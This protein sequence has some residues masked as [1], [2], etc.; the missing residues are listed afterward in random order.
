MVLAVVSMGREGGKKRKEGDGG[1]EGGKGRRGEREGREMVAY[2]HDLNLPMYL[3]ASF[4]P[5]LHGG[6]GVR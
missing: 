2:L 6:R 3:L 1:R 4:L 5:P